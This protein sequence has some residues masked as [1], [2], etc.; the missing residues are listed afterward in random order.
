M[1]IVNPVAV[2]AA[3]TNQEALFIRHLLTEAGIEAGVTEDLSLAGL[4]VLGTMPSI[5]N[6]KVW[7]DQTREADATAL[8]K[9]YEERRFDRSK[10]G[11]DIPADA[12]PIEVRCENCGETSQFPAVQR[13][14]V[15][16]CPNCWANVDVAPDED[17]DEWWKVGAEEER[18]DE[19]PP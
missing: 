13:G 8:L 14:S 3:E 19:L 12:G 11:A 18:G 17:G 1:A 5:H 10:H 2:Y 15:Q 7:V 16:S 9:Q 4:W 6:P